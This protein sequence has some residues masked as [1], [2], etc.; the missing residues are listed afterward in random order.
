MPSLVTNQKLKG[1]CLSEKIEN[2]TIRRSSTTSPISVIWAVNALAKVTYRQSV[3]KQIQNRGDAVAQNEK[4][5]VV[6]TIS[7][8]G[9]NGGRNSYETSKK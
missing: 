4:F 7:Q 5:A 6:R 3:L 1:R 2:F 8:G 9:E